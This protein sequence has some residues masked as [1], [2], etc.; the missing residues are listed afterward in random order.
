MKDDRNNND[1]TDRN[2]R[3]WI[4]SKIYSQFNNGFFCV[5]FFQR[6][7][8]LTFESNTLVKHHLFMC[9]RTSTTKEEKKEY[10]RHQ[11]PL[12]FLF[13]LRLKNDTQREREKKNHP[14][15]FDRI[16]GREGREFIWL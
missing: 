6:H 3:R 16:L 8:S 2:I 9:I 4:I 1:S 15:P 5:F 14:F 7:I 12:F 11:S 13:F 10:T